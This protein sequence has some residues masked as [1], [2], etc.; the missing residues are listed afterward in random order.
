[1]VVVNKVTSKQNTP[2]MKAKLE[3]I[4]KMRIGEKPRRHMLHEMTMR[5]LPLALLGMKK[6]T[7]ALKPL[8]PIA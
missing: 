8:Y 7:C 2:T 6:Q 4:S 3:Q 1:M 5:Y